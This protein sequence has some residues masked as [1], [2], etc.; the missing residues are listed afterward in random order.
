[1]YYSLAVVK[2]CKGDSL[3]SRARNCN[4]HAAVLNTGTRAAVKVEM[5]CST[6]PSRL[7]Q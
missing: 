6:S 7:C 2:T 5:S 1:M 4:R 3:K